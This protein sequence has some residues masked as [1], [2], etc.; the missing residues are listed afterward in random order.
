MKKHLLIIGAGPGVALGVAHRFGHEGF[1][2]SLV[3]RRAGS[4][5]E[6]AGQLRVAGI[7]AATY[8]A[9]VADFAQLAQVIQT[10]IAERGPV[11]LLHY[12][13]SVYRE[14]TGLTL[15]PEQFMQDMRTDAGGLLAAVQAVVP[16]MQAAGGGAVLVTG[17]GAALYPSGDLLSLSVGKAAVRTMAECLRQTLEPMNIRVATVTIVGGVGSN[18]HFSP[19]QI[20]R[21]FWDLHQQPR[22]NWTFETIYR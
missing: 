21:A 5:D 18:D 8:L 20:A 9:D 19:E 10:V 4:L 1:A 6:R 2:V 15:E 13:P 16:A 17:G 3:A 11:T 14:A 7:D 12:N 22:D